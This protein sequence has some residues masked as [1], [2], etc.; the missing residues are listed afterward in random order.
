MPYTKSA[1]LV[2]IESMGVN[3]PL[4]KRLL[5]IGNGIIRRAHVAGMVKN[6]ANSIERLIMFL[7]SLV[8]FF[9]VVFESLGNN[10]MPMAIPMTPKGNW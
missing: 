8:R 3:A 10:T 7:L 5:I 4:S 9:D 2:F 1:L 6:K